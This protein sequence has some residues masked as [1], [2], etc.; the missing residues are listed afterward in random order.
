MLVG[1]LTLGLIAI[2]LRSADLGQVWVEIGRARWDLL[3]AATIVTCA[4][5][6][7]RAL[8]WQYLL[9]PIGPTHFMTAF[10]TTVIG[11]SATFLLPGRVGEFL[12]PYLLARREGLDVTACF[13][14]IIVERLLDLLTV[15]M[16]FA[17]FVLVFDPGVAASDP[18]VFRA[19]VSGGFVAAAA[20]V[21]G[22]VTLF[23]LAGHPE[24]LGRVALGVERVLPE[25]FAHLLSRLLTAF[26][27]GLAVVR[28]PRR[29]LITLCL[30]LS[31]WLSIAVG[32]WLVSRSFGMP[33]PY[34]GS[35]LLTALLVVGVA[36]PTPGGIGGFHEM[37]RIGATSFYGTQN[38]RA[39]GA[40]IVLHAVSFVPVALAGL[41]FMAQDGLSLKSLRRLTPEADAAG[42]DPVL[43]INGE[44]AG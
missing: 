28:Q 3:A 8:R 36:A 9:Q 24:A 19:V 12:R 35:F 43:K 22:F 32:I 5:Y 30:S 10:R 41:V 6:L 31:L 4:T 20:G 44:L 14:T 39:V 38:D 37:F 11:F 7:I 1:V 26:A 16:L 29:L 17:S 27:R 25:R 15:V 42:R 18:R 13:A 40:A 21:A 2:F 33:L 34:T 23:F